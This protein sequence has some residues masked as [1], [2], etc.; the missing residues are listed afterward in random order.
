MKFEILSALLASTQCIGIGGDGL[1]NGKPIKNIHLTATYILN[2][3][4]DMVEK[5]A[6]ESRVA[7]SETNK[8]YVKELDRKL[9]TLSDERKH[10]EDGEAQATAM[11]SGDKGGKVDEFKGKKAIIDFGATVESSSKKYDG[12]RY[13]PEQ[14]G[15]ELRLDSETGYEGAMDDIWIDTSFPNNEKFKVQNFLWKKHGTEG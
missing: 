6:K 2:D 13:E 11:L 5:E 10:V 3:A 12:T 9:K 15:P 4:L 1:I 7:E 8:D 14:D